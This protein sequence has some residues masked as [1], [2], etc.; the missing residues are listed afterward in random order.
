MVLNGSVR[1]SEV[2]GPQHRVERWD[3]PGMEVLNG[4]GRLKDRLLA[5][6]G[7]RVVR[8]PLPFPHGDVRRWVEGAAGA[9]AASPLGPARPQ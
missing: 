4:P 9:Q 5:K 6:R 8:L 7:W 3:R 1:V 2:D